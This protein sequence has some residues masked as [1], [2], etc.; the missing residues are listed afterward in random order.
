MHV[1]YVAL[2]VLLLFAGL[3]TELARVGRFT[4][5]LPVVNL[6]R[7]LVD[8]TLSAVVALVRPFSRVD[9]QVQDAGGAAREGPW[10]V[11]ASVI[12][13]ASVIRN[14]HLHSRRSAQHFATDIADEHLFPIRAVF[15][16]SMAA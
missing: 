7:A 12:L 3:S 5:V 1:A 6:Q 16:L 8:E 2:E 15:G 14:V 10:T 9:A 4:G 11:M 13:L